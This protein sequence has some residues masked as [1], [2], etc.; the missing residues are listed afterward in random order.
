MPV[1]IPANGAYSRFVLWLAHHGEWFWAAIAVLF[2][3]A[4]LTRGVPDVSQVPFFS[5]VVAA[6]AV[7]RV[8]IRHA[9][10]LCPRCAAAVP[11][12]GAL[13]A[14]DRAATLRWTHYLCPGYSRRRLLVDG[15]LLAAAVVVMALRVPLLVVAIVVVLGFVVKSVDAYLVR[16][17]DPLQPWCPHCHWDDGGD[18]DDTDVPDPVPPSGVAMRS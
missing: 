9:R 4:V 8:E 6:I 11:L 1:S 10:V 16:V 18:E 15:A 13:R 3:L 14:Q 5:A 2:G 12:D 7:T 17:H